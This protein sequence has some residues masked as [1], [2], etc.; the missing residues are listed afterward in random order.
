MYSMTG[1]GKASGTFEK[2]PLRIEVKAVNHRFCE[3]N[4]R[5]PGKYAVLEI[6]IQKYIKDHVKRGRVDIFLNEDKA[7]VLSGVETRAFKSYYG[8][9]NEI[10]T[11]LK[12]KEDISLQQLLSGINSW[13]QKETS[14]KKLWQGIK[15]ILEKAVKDLNKMRKQEGLRLKKF[16]QGRV[17]TLQSLRKEI[18]KTNDKIRDTLAK[19]MSDRIAEKMEAGTELDEQRLHTEVV[20]YLDRMD[21]SEEL[22]R[23]E[24]HLVHMN[25]FLNAKEP[26]GRK[27]DFL[28]QEFNREFNT[29]ASKSQSVGIAHVVVEAKA[30]L[31]KIREQIQ[32]IE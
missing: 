22:E 20:Y 26:I 2:K 4:T 11:S 29:I 12:L 24:S 23:L 28:L 15:P 10:K 25:V 30:E 31:E 18:S 9:L 13:I 14:E 32:N 21:I 8:Y 17:K 1:M 16:L 7:T 27:M 6:L 5:V 19:K 3:V